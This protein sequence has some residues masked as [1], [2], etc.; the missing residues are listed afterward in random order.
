MNEEIDY[1]EFLRDLILTSAI[2][3][4]TLESILEDNQD[5]LYTEQDTVYYSLIGT[6]KSCR[7]I[8][9]IRT[10]S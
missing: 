2:R 5:C 10:I 8:K 3:T 6:Y 4:E 1:N 9:R 7:H